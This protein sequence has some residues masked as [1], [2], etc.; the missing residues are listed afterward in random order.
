MQNNTELYLLLADYLMSAYGW[1]LEYT[2]NI[3]ETTPKD[4]IMNLIKRIKSR[5]SENARL[6]AYFNSLAV[7]L[8]LNGKLDSLKSLLSDTTEEQEDT[9]AEYKTEEEKA[10]QE[11]NIA[12]GEMKSLYILMGK[13]TAEQFEAD[14]AKGNIV[15]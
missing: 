1:T 8:V 14:F 11:F 12:K 4:V 6:H 10:E 9:S 13:G 2:L 15:L 5:E 3:I 7:G